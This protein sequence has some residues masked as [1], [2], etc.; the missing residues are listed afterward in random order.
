M[1][2][3]LR[4][5]AVAVAL[6]AAMVGLFTL[7]QVND[8]RLS[9]SSDL[10]YRTHVLS[11]SLAESFGPL[12]AGGTGN[13][14]EATQ[15]IVDRISSEERIAG[16]A[17]YNTAPQVFAFS[18]G[19]PANSIALADVATVMDSDQASGRFESIGGINDYVSIEPLHSGEKVVG[20][21]ALIQNAAYIDA[22]V[23]D[24]WQRNLVRFFIQIS[25]FGAAIFVLIRF[26]FYK[27]VHELID[28]VRA[29]RR[30]E[31]DTPDGNY[32]FLDPLSNEIGKI[33]SSLRQARAV[34][35]EEAR[36]RLE[37]LDSPWTAERLKE[38]IKA[39]VKER[40]I[41]VLSNGEPFVHEKKNKKV[42]WH[43]P[44]GGVVTALEPLM[45][46]CGG[47]W[48]ARGAGSADKETVDKNAKIAV[49]PD[50]PRYTLKR[51]FLS[52]KEAEGYYRGFSNEALWP[53]S[54]MAHVRPQ[55]RK[56][57]WT[58]YR[59]VNG[60]FAKTL[61]D[62][63]EIV[64]R[65]IVLV[66]DYHLALVPSLIIRARPD[67]E[68]ALF[69]HIPWPS[70]AQFSI[71]PWRKEILESMLCADL[72]GFHTQNY[73]N[74]FIET[75]AA[76]LESRIDY[77]RFSIHRREH[78]TLVKAFPISIAFPGDAEETHEPDAKTWEKLG[79]RSEF[80]GLGVDRL[81]YIKGIPE[82]FRGIEF[83][84]DQHP[85]YREQFTFLQVAPATRVG[86]E[87]F[88]QYANQVLA[89]AE[90]I[91]KK[92]GTRDWKPIVVENRRYS[93]AELKNLYA[94]ADVCAITSIHDGMNLVAK[95]YVAAH[96][97]KGGALI[98]SQ[99]AGASRD[100]KGALVV[101][102][103]SA[104]ETADALLRS[105]TMP[106]AEQHRRMK[107]MRDSVERYNVFRW[108]AEIIK[109][110][111]EIG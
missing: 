33:S 73:C 52:E 40:P 50:E 1:K 28:S 14:V 16:L 55:F 74:N 71:C 25:I 21:L 104:E 83:F 61:L 35:S 13:T 41:Y 98:L 80:V 24:V 102:P 84:F 46:A 66:Q 6:V 85:D 44:A 68:V 48:I 39:Y 54:H 7:N 30:G 57:D 103:Y 19:Y 108:A 56:E 88:D 17:V 87:K 93:H 22:A 63:V 4:I 34:A 109:T 8:E 2:Q 10:E 32:G 26:V 3:A 78:E 49:P 67:A 72:L 86:T 97:D 95:E 29:A 99:F 12:L 69:W 51:I 59:R 27:A 111:T 20:A 107:L 110:L 65:P 60:R 70:A 18:D 45:E 15:K 31:R 9:L 100:L 64:E 77:E 106:V 101:N 11:D 38:F 96:G 89:E 75:T 42:E 5:T 90:R 91:N 47:V 23:R 94:L 53:L 43:V 37:K 62:E 92:F 76:E 79:I 36:M 82:R 81:D 58:E 105:L